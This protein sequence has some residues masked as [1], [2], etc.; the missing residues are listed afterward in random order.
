[1]SDPKTAKD[2]L[3]AEPSEDERKRVSR[4]LVLAQLENIRQSEREAYDAELAS[5]LAEFTTKPDRSQL[6]ELNPTGYTRHGEPVHRMSSPTWPIY[7]RMSPEER[8][9]RNPDSDHWMAEWLR[10]FSSRDHARMAIANAKLEGMFGRATVNEGVAGAA[11]AESTGTGGALIP[12]PLEAVVM[13]ARD[14]EAKAR[15]FATIYQ[16][17]RQNHQIPTAAAMTA[18]MVGESTSSAQGE[19]TFA[20]V[21]LIAKVACVKAVATEELLDDSAVNVVNVFAVRGGGAL[22][23][24]EDDQVFKLGDGT[25]NNI[26]T[27]FGGVAYTEATSTILGFKD[28]AGMYFGLPQQYRTGSV[29]MAPGAVLNLLTGVRGGSEGR[30]LYAGMNETPRAFVDDP[31][32]IGSIFGRPV[33]EIPMTPG[34]IWFGNP[35]QHYA[36]GS[37]Q[38]IQVKVSEHVRFAEREI[39]WLITERFAGNVVDSTAAV[40][41]DGITSAT[42]AW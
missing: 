40:V 8:E 1:M 9:W 30:P 32:A 7:R 25:G 37:R 11:G 14:R 3:P 12:R 15:R 6:P 23:V 38:G 26:S 29:W 18:S 13:I 16:M 20:S 31:W 34:R 28:I 10:G 22:G 17:T 2:P 35:E 5:V 41:T 24:L 36:F 39:M 33:Y 27:S 4:S 42:N 19:P 21:D